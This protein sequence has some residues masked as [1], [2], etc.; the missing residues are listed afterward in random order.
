MHLRSAYRWGS[1]LL[2]TRMLRVA[3]LVSVCIVFMVVGLNIAFWLSR[4][5]PPEQVPPDLSRC[6]RIEV[7][8]WPYVLGYPVFNDEAERS[9]VSPEEMD[10]VERLLTTVID[11]PDA[12]KNF[13]HTI[14]S[15]SYAGILS[16][17]VSTMN[18]ADLIVHFMDKPP[19]SLMVFD[20]STVVTE[21]KRIFNY[22]V[23]L[24]TFDKIKSQVFSSKLLPQIQSRIACGRNLRVLY[25]ALRGPGSPPMYPPASTWCDVVLERQLHRGDV[26]RHVWRRFQCPTMDGDR[27]TYALNS[28]CTSDSPADTV[29]L[30]ETKN[31][32]NE[33]GGPELFTFENHDPRGGLVLL[34][35]GTVLFIRTEEELMR[36]RWR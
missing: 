11:D 18:V 12:V 17:S 2:S 5:V 7:Q 10:L 22:R 1:T 28:L 29:L 36:L 16:G 25:D 6:T 4:K 15:G 27:C 23:P 14:P 33:H 34:H 9:L 30:F 19:V 26:E 31:G 13:A 3:T 20:D 32:W 8:Y 24:G 21:D 35:D